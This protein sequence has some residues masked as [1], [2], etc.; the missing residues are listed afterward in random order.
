MHELLNRTALTIARF[1]PGSF[2][3]LIPAGLDRRPKVFGIGFHKTGTTTLGCALRQLGYRVQKGCAFNH[4]GKP[5][6]LEPVTLDKLWNVVR[7]MV[8]LY[9][10]FEDNPWPLLF[11]QIDDAFPGSRFIFTHRDPERWI[12]SASRYFGSKS[13]ATLD[14]IYGQRGFRIAGN[15][16]I[17]LARYERHNAEVMDYFRDRRDDI[18]VWNLASESDWGPLCRFLN[19]PV[20]GFPFPHANPGTR[21]RANPPAVASAA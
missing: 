15:E 5:T 6:V 8:T 12:R 7:P 16:A 18:L 14:L 13:N 17:A 11:R 1:L 21:L 10:A 19:C 20:P 4:P 2:D 3:P 9:G